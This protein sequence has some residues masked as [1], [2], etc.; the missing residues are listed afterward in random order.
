VAVLGG[1]L[2]MFKSVEHSQRLALTG[3]RTF[4]SGVVKL[5]YENAE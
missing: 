2:A 1:G 3:T 4:P 5:R